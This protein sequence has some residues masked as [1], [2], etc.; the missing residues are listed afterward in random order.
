MEL[1]VRILI[2]D[3]HQLLRRGV[4]MILKA[5]P[6]FQVVGEASDGQEALDMAGELQPHLVL[7]NL[8]MPGMDGI[9][10]IQRLRQQMPLVRVLVLSGLT[11]DGKVIAAIRAGAQGY[12]LKTASPEDLVQAILSVADGNSWLHPVIARKVLQE[13]SHPCEQDA[14]AHPESQHLSVLTERE[15]QVLRM[16]ALG[17]SNCLI[18]D[19][20][21][22]GEATVRTH[23]SSILNKLHL[24]SRTQ[25]ALY[26]L[27][28][29][30]VSLDDIEE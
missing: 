28:E 27:K 18:A 5:D 25:A 20:M 2:V 26:A 16:L 8:V 29:G 6:R 21:E 10:A 1:P 12:L 14:S 3:D 24:T 23:V 19:R 13:I 22:I 17:L 4:A 11:D 9:E 15:L 7:T 30:L